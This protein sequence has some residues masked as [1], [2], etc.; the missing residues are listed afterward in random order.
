MVLSDFLN[1]QFQ[2]QLQEPLSGIINHGS[3]TSR[4]VLMDVEIQKQKRQER[5][6]TEHSSDFCQENHVSHPRFPPLTKP[7]PSFLLRNVAGCSYVTLQGNEL[8]ILTS[9]SVF[10]KM[11][12]KGNRPGIPPRYVLFIALCDRQQGGRYTFSCG[13]KY[14]FSAA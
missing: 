6:W 3:F 14:S 12:S 9:P 1:K 5:W 4:L 11:C 10:S 2:S 8:S 13:R 7:L